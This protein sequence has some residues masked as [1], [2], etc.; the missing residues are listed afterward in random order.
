MPSKDY[1]HYRLL[2]NENLINMIEKKDIEINNLKES[3]K[4]TR[5]SRNKYCAYNTFHIE[6]ITRLDK[7]I[8]KYVKRI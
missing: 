1:D 7:I 3:L 5:E 6:E 8:G 2:S 4:K